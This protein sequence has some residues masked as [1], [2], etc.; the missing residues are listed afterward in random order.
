MIVI[1]LLTPAISIEKTL[2][3]KTVTDVLTFQRIRV[4]IRF[5]AS[6]IGFWK[7]ETSLRGFLS[8]W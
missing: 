5:K 7:L 8:L 2:F 3:Y 6:L 1:S 4:S